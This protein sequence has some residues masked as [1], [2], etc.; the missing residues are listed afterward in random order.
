MYPSCLGKH[1]QQSNAD[2]HGFQQDN[3]VLGK[4]MPIG[5]Y[6]QLEQATLCCCSQLNLLSSLPLEIAQVVQEIWYSQDV[7]STAFGDLEL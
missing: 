2:G 5:Y 6:E 4:S 1:P 3:T 7:T